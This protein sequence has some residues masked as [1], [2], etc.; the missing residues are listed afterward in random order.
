[1]LR[2]DAFWH[3]D[4]LLFRGQPLSPKNEVDF[5]TMFPHD[6]D[7]VAAGRHCNGIM[8]NRVPGYPLLAVRAPRRKQP[9]RLQQKWAPEMCLWRSGR[10]RAQ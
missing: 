5:L 1:M 4:M 9:A 2:Q 3:Y 7:A 8:A 10:S 6:T